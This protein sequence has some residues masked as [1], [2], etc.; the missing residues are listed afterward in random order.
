MPQGSG[1]NVLQDARA[2]R[3]QNEAVSGSR[4]KPAALAL[5]AALLLSLAP[6]NGSDAV[7][8]GACHASEL[9]ARVRQRT[10]GE[11]LAAVGELRAAGSVTTSGLSGQATFGDDT[12]TGRYFRRFDVALMGRSA[13]VF[14]GTTL[15]SQDI[16]G[17]VHAR[18]AAFPRALAITNAF[19][20]RR[21][22]LEAP[23][24]RAAAVSCRPPQTDGGRS[25]TVVRVRPANG[26][27]ADLAIDAGTGTLIRV[28]ERLPLT[29]A[30]TTYGDYRRVDGMLLPFS[31]AS[32]TLSQP[33]N[34]FRF[35]V[36][37]Y[38]ISRRANAVD[39][40]PPA[41]RNPAVMLASRTSTTVP[42][43]LEGHQLMVWA[44]INGHAPLP[45]ILDTGGHAIL[46]TGSARA[47]GLAANGHGESGGSGSHTT[48]V[49]Y[50]RV[51]SIRIGDAEIRDQPML[52]IAYPYAFYER[53]KRTPLAGI[54]GLE[55]FERFAARLDYGDR[56]VTFTPLSSVRAHR[57]GSAVPL[58]FQDDMP[59][60][61]AAADGHTGTFGVD[62]GNA[63]SLI[64]FGT[65]LRKHGFLERYAR[66]RTLIGHGTGG[67]NS[68]TRQ[69]LR[70]LR[71]GGH[72]LHDTPAYFTQMRSGS[73]SSWTEAGNIGYTVL[74]R[75]VPT[76]DYAR[77]VMELQ[78]STSVRPLP[79]NRSGIRV[80]KNVPD[81]FDVDAVE[82]GSAGAT[83]GIS[84]GDRIV[85]VNGRPAD[86]FSR[87]DFVT[88]TEQP[89]GTIV[90]LRVERR[91][92][93]QDVRMRLHA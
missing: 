26:I 34:G 85:A 13:E 81:A 17:G 79:I 52:V 44:R 64:L 90:R 46:T 88:L 16:S 38:A 56:Q 73:F 63:G 21:R 51:R 55:W 89:S 83:S 5:A 7:A 54:I 36:S 91:G 25:L 80:S 42:M 76:F 74:S 10:V 12:R 8:G 24:P 27:P 32:G 37:H 50:A 75:F 65:F 11:R 45:F 93:P 23:D 9:L 14:D 41:P 61:S 30:V 86:D 18:D 4:T 47:L 6:A 66:G 59:L 1:A 87:A 62:T 82:P 20:A 78:A 69:T 84:A 31:I 28:A 60:V 57:R 92:R 19:L 58:R 48:G 68:G 33:A 70:S 22:Y 3:E 40:A 71:I 72:V 2:A 77:G 49:Q 35:A 43:M 39:F 29:T 67:S 53:G 15:W